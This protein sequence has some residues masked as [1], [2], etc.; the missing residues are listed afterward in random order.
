M[1]PLSQQE[2]RLGGHLSVAYSFRYR[3]WHWG[4]VDTIEV[5]QTAG[6]SYVA[7]NEILLFRDDNMICSIYSTATTTSAYVVYVYTNNPEPPSPQLL[8]SM[9]ALNDF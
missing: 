1:I 4:V 7:G 9:L 8:S 3:V 5:I 6:L 2:F